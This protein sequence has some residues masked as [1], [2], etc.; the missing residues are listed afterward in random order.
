MTRPTV[1]N[2]APRELT[3]EQRY[4]LKNRVEGE[5]SLRQAAIFALGYWAGLRISEVAQLQL[6]YFCIFPQ[7]GA[8]RYFLSSK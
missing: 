1:V 4:V 5:R 7:N 2:T 8:F 6:G 3:P